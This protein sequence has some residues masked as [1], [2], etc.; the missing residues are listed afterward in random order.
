MNKF[1]KLPL[2][3]GVVGG[4]CTAVLATTYAITNPEFLK[5]ET[6]RKN[7][8]FKDILVGFGLTESDGSIK[9]GVETVEY[10]IESEDPNFELSSKIIGNV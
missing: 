5:R 3:L 2:F 7:A 1:L 10:V 9:T 6:E 8:A 4:L